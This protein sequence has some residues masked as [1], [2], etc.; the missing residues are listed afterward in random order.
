MIW[1]QGAKFVA[2]RSF[3]VSSIEATTA[4]ILERAYACVYLATAFPWIYPVGL[5]RCH[6]FLAR[7]VD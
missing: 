2:E 3:I 4:L 6:G 1:L 5:E 7:T